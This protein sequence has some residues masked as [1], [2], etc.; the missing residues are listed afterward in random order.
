MFTVLYGYCSIHIYLYLCFP[1][2]SL[3]FCESHIHSRVKCWYYFLLLKHMFPDT[4]L[5]SAWG[6][7]LL[8]HHETLQIHLM[9]FSSLLFVCLHVQQ[10]DPISALTP[11]LQSCSINSLLDS[12]VCLEPFVI[13]LEFHSKLQRI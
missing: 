1:V 5:Y 7:C 4:T 12:S 11:V 8:F 10:P 3:L 13:K 2:Y 9:F 6:I